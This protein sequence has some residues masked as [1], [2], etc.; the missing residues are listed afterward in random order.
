MEKL[1]KSLGIEIKEMEF[2]Q[3][4]HPVFG[5]CLTRAEACEILGWGTSTGERIWNSITKRFPELANSSEKWIN[6]RGVT[7]YKLQHPHRLRDFDDPCF[8]EDKIVRRF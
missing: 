8:G 7:R 1:I 2:I 3:L 4:I 5:N 6:P